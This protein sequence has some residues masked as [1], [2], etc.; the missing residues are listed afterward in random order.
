MKFLDAS[1]AIQFV[2]YDP[3]KFTDTIINEKD[4]SNCFH[5][6]DYVFENILRDTY[7]NIHN[8]KSFPIIKQVDIIISSMPD[9][10]CENEK[11]KVVEKLF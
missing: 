1:K 7:L 8:F 6:S 5:R 10:K 3:V 11:Q 2:P 4:C 9:I